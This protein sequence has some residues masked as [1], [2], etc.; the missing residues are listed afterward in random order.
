MGVFLAEHLKPNPIEADEDEFLS[1]EKMPLQEVMNLVKS[2]KI[3]DAKTLAALMIAKSH[4]NL[5]LGKK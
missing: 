3:P 2:N 5:I 1:V 4:L